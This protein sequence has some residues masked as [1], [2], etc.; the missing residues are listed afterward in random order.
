RP[1][2]CALPPRSRRSTS[3]ILRW[4]GICGRASAPAGTASTTRRTTSSGKPEPAGDGAELASP[5]RTWRLSHERG[6]RPRARGDGPMTTIE[7][8]AAAE[9]IVGRL[10]AAALGTAELFNI[11][12]GQV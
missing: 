7:D 5:R 9:A 8:T 3:S 6:N 4:A 12:L 10:F 2:R 11:Y 1:C